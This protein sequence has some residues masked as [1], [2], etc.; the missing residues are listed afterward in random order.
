MRSWPTKRI[1]STQLGSNL[2]ISTW[3]SGN[4]II[5]KL[6]AGVTMPP[7]MNWIHWVHA[8]G[9]SRCVVYRSLCIY[10]FECSWVSMIIGLQCTYMDFPL[11][12]IPT[13]RIQGP[14]H[15]FVLHMLLTRSYI[16][17][18]S[19]VSMAQFG[20]FFASDSAGDRRGP[21]GVEKG[22]CG[23]S[24]TSNVSWDLRT[25]RADLEPIPGRNVK[26]GRRAVPKG[27]N[28]K[29]LWVESNMWI[30]LWN[31][32]RFWSILSPFWFTARSWIA[33]V[34]HGRSGDFIPSSHSKPNSLQ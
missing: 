14:G 1:S 21:F 3:W 13:D 25:D 9:I 7:E 11:H 16:S 12:M 15:W 33:S 30:S 19:I 28:E 23:R 32:C 24:A 31:W 6:I 4:M 22:R 34:L 8:V 5:L 2:P 26:I 17:M 20:E 18:T 10:L 29:I 27:A